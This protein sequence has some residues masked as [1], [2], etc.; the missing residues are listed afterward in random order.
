MDL[1]AKLTLSPSADQIH[2]RMPVIIAEQHHAAWLGE[3]E[4]GNLKELLVHFS[5]GVALDGV[6]FTHG[7]LVRNFTSAGIT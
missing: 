2:P 6:R 4:D 5:F 7:W 3:T 1:D